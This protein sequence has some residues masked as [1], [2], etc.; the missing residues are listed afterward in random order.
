M[1]D[2]EGGLQNSLEYH[3]HKISAHCCLASRHFL[4]LSSN[5]NLN[6]CGHERCWY[7][8]A[9]VHQVGIEEAAMKGELAKRNVDE[10]KHTAR[11]NK[12]GRSEE[13]FG[14]YGFF[15]LTL[16]YV[17]ANHV[18]KT[19]SFPHNTRSQQPRQER[20]G[21]RKEETPNRSY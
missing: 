2:F 18:Q 3:P 20:K 21:H 16:G 14:R 11:Q 8:Q 4:I 10:T 17:P 15:G 19:C 5:H 7:R 12:R 9:K 1:F 6:I 13:R